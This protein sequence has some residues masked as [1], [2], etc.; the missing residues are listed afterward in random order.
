MRQAVLVLAGYNIRAVVAFCRWA[1]SHQIDFHIVARNNA[2]LIFLT[3]YKVKVDFVRNSNELSPKD[4][5]Q[6]KKIL[7]ERCGYDRILIL[8]STE[9]LN[10]FLVEHQ[11][12]IE[13]ENLL[14]PLAEASVYRQIS[15]KYSFSKLCQSYNLDVPEEFSSIPERLPFVAKPRKYLSGAGKQLVPQLVCDLDD[16]HK[17]Q[18]NE[19]AEDYFFQQFVSGRSLY[20]LA[21][22]QLNKEDVLFSQENLVQQACGGS[23][24]LAKRSDFHLTKVAQRYVSMLHDI[25]FYGPIMIEVRYETATNRYFMIEANPR[26]WGP[27]QFAIDNC[28]DILGTWLRGYGFTPHTQVQTILATDFYYWSGGIAHGTKPLKFHNYSCNEFMDDYCSFKAQDIFFRQDTL[29]LYCHE[30][31]SGAFRGS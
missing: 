25:N 23:I 27:L 24:I 10:R 9:Y 4:F 11:V 5:N 17:F 21:C 29:G 7:C 13:D 19:C 20:L 6:W 2:D 31:G 1:T 22:I 12:E 16:L 30:H 26:L 14:I 15:D 18:K 28:V 8:P 3:N